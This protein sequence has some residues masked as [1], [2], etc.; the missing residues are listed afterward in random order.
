VFPSHDLAASGNVNPVGD[1]VEALFNS[2]FSLTINRK[3][4]LPEFPV[5]FFKRVGDTQV[6]AT[7]QASYPNGLYG[8]APFEPVKIDG[9]MTIDASISIG[10]GVDLTPA[11]GSNYAV[12]ECRGYLVT[13][14]KS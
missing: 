6:T 10:T 12:L 3:E 1:N 13:N 7:T 9:R 11:A 5:R 14:V 8:F 4:F 2:S